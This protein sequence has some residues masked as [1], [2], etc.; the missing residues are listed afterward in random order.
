MALEIVRRDMMRWSLR[1]RRLASVLATALFAFVW[2]TGARWIQV[3]LGHTSAYSG[4]TLLTCLIG[5]SLIGMRKRLVMLPLW[6]VSTWVQ[7]HIYTA[8][9]ACVAFWVH[10]PAVI[11]NGWFEGALSWLFLL[12]AASGLY[13]VVI[14]RLAPKRLTAVSIQPRFDRIAWHRDQIMVA[15]DAALLELD[16]SSDRSVL[17]SHFQQRLKPYFQSSLS[18]RYLAHPTSTRRRR[19][20]ADLAELDRYLDG[21]V[22]AA[23]KQL[24][25]LIRHRDDLDYQHAIQLRLRA[26]VMVHGSLSGVL[27]LWSL[28]HAYLA[29]GMLGT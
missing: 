5:L 29:I 8:L 28:A 24:A 22:L 13:G 3:R 16:E 10:V 19:L 2:L 26:W 15:A 17:E 1:Q 23:S 18:L 9:F 12:V 27:L 21:S 20:L 14:S 4:A 7:I 11:G 6:S 25:A